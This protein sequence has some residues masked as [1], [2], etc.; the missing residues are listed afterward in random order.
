M[1]TPLS[2]GVLVLLAAAVALLALILHK[3]RRVHLA[4]FELRE[5]ASRTCQESE[6][7]FAQIQSLLALERTL[8]LEQPLPP[9]RGWAGSPDFLLAAAQEVLASR[10]ATVVECGSGVSTVVL[11][12]C[13]QLNGRGH[14][15]SLEHE[16]EFAAKTRALLERHR[17]AE[18]ANVIDAPL[19]TAQTASPWY[20]LDKLPA[21][22]P[23]INMLV[24]DGPPAGLAPLARL[25]AVPQLM[26]RMAP[27]AAVFIDDANRDA[28]RE[29]VRRWRS[30][31]PAFSQTDLYCEKGLTVLRLPER[32]A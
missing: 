11:A 27:A 2:L 28:E 31:F 12:R 19:Q 16:A 13:V 15:Y 14:L 6:A 17:L 23:P 8:R 29:I 9:M 26:P 5:L 30:E 32:A 20:S 21:D 25:P 10:P 7:L 4:T 22:L 3:V 24:V 18:W 1:T